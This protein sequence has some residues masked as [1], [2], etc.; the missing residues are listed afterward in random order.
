MYRVYWTN[1]GYF[2]IQEFENL[3][4]ARKY[5]ASRCYEHSIYQGDV[6]VGSWTV[7]GGWRNE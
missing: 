3:D 6:R 7:F 1:F 4:E 5:G 2:A